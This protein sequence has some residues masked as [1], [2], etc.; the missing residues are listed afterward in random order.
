MHNIVIAGHG[1]A[2]LTAGDTLRRQGFEGTLTIIGEDPHP[3]YS[4]SLIHI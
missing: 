2:G 1:I 4:L 3:T